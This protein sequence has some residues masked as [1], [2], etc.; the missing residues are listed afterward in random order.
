MNT[1]SVILI[2]RNEQANLDAC[3]SSVKDIANEIVVVDS[4]SSDETL[5]I[6]QSYNA[7]ISS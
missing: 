7:V 2:T 1:L 6:A 3:L 5:A 4:M